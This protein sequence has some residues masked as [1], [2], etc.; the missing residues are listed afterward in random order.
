MNGSR[1]VVTAFELGSSY[2]MVLFANG[3][4]KTVQPF[5]FTVA[6]HGRDLASRQ[7]LPLAL[8]WGTVCVV[9]G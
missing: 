3:I 8:A 9:E 4:S 1:G 2:P 6:Q 7:Q 5:K